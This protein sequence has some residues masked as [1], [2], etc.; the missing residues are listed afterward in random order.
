MRFGICTTDFSK[1]PMD[2]LF[3]E[4]AS[5]GYECVQFAFPSVSECGFVETGSIEI[6]PEIPFDLADAVVNCAEKHGLKIVSI[7]GTFNMAHPDAD[8]REEGAGRLKNLIEAAEHMG[9]P[10]ITICTGSRSRESLWKRDEANDTQEAWNDTKTTLI[11]CVRHA[12]EHNVSLLIE[13]EAS[14]TVRTAK[15]ARKMLDEITSPA[16]KIVLDP[17]NLF[18]PGTAHAGN[19]ESVLT[20]A[21]GLLSDEIVLA[22]GKDIREGDGISFCAAGKG[23]VDFA[24]LKRLL[25]DNDVDMVLHGIYD[26]NDMERALFYMKEK[27]L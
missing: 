25:G 18:L 5:M 26:E 11:P 23:I 19:V 22:H 2:A 20:E 1:R 17:A 21:V 15:K 8:I 9:V 3:D 7:N 6:P 24:L 27:W 4:I 10:F 13:T 16:L 14:N 12:E